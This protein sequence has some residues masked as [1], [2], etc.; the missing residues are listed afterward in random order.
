M[1]SSKNSEVDIV[2]NVSIRLTPSNVNAVASAIFFDATPP[3]TAARFVKTDSTTRGNWIGVYGSDA[4]IIA[5]DSARNASY[6]S[7]S[8]RDQSEWTYATDGKDA[9]ALLKND[10][11]N[12]IA[13]VWYSYY[14]TT[15]SFY[16]DITI[17]DGATHQVALYALDWYN[18][19]RALQ[20]DVLNA[21]GGAVFDSRQLASYAGGIYLVWD[22]K[23]RLRLRLSTLAGANAM[24][25]GIFLGPPSSQL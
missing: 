16:I 17:S 19:G 8:V 6:A 18:Q 9:R 22:I 20:V 4:S 2:G 14:P 23:G 11:K 1:R 10:G 25:S 12:R 13:G 3:S 7:V 21:D 15:N 5:R 24:A